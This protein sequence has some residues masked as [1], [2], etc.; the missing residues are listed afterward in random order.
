[1]TRCPRPTVTAVV[2]AYN[3]ERF[4]AD[5]IDSALGQDYPAELLDVVV[6]NDGST[7]GTGRVLDARFGSNPRVRIVHQEN[8]GFVG[9]MNRAL[10][11][12]TR[13][14]IAL[15]D[16]DDMWPLDK[17]AR[18]VAVLEQRPEVG[19]V[20]GDMEVV[21]DDGRTVVHESF[22]RFSRFDLRRGRVLA[23]LI[24]QCFVSGG[25]S[26]FRAA[27]LERLLPIPAELHYPDWYVATQIAQ[28]AEI[29]HVD[30][31][32]N[33]Y[34]MHGANMGLGGTGT[35]FFSD[36]RNNVRIQR[37]MLRH[38]DTSAEP[39]GDL[40]AAAGIMVGRTERA[41]LELGLRPTAIHAVTGAEREAAAERV[42]AAGAAL[43]AGRLDDALRGFVAAL[44][45]NPFDGAARAELAVGAARRERLETA[46]R[47]RG[48]APETRDAVVVAFA[49]ELVAAPDMLRSYARAV[50]GTAPVTLLIAAEP[51]KADEL[52]GSLGDV[53]AQAGLDADDAADVLLHPCETPDELLLT[54]LRALYTR[55]DAPPVLAGLPRVED[56]SL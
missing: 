17:L 42:A 6:V 47:E 32:V 41:A 40:C 15:L 22:F 54:P 44:A 53:A 5:A 4:V 28:W 27:F 26:V 46:V 31:S 24:G 38:L 48:G 8:R 56:A 23:P 2:T 50:P 36:M 20:H 19:L 14:L 7:D 33:R 55:R 25:A 10:G 16:G 37:W 35:K 45:L 21:G 29:D 9:A 30:G 39:V 3:H 12:A 11:E 34:R 43:D 52:A 18:Q 13:E 1:M 51:A 49:S